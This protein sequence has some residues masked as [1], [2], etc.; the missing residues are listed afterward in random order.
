MSVDVKSDVLHCCHRESRKS[1]VAVRF[2]IAMDFY[3]LPKYSMPV[4]LQV[5]EII[6][7]T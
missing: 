1:Q 7:D 3:L 6:P 5:A 4:G 2:M